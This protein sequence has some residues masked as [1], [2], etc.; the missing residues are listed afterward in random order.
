[1]SLAPAHLSELFGRLE[2]VKQAVK[3]SVPAEGDGEGRHWLVVVAHGD[4]H[5]EQGRS[6]IN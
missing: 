6:A 1:M 4:E 3:C 5:D 2:R